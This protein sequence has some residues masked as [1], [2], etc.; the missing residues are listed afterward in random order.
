MRVKGSIVY[1]G[2]NVWAA[3]VEEFELFLTDPKNTVEY[4]SF[5]EKLKK[6]EKSNDKYT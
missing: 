2:D 1:E 4:E 5:K 3:S 6:G